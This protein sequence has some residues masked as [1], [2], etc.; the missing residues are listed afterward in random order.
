MS[1]SS[2]R[3]VRMA[4]L[5]LFIPPISFIPDIDMNF[6]YRVSCPFIKLQ[7]STLWREPKKRIGLYAM[8]RDLGSQLVQINV[9]HH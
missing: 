5:G 2:L 7:S 6:G 9:D 1:T 8:A 4:D 3:M